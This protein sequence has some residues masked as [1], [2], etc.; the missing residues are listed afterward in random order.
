MDSA[1]SAGASKLKVIIYIIIPELKALFLGYILYYFESN[2]RNA[3]TLGLVG[4]G[5]IGLLLIMDIHLFRYHE[6]CTI[7]LIIIVLI[8]VMDRLSFM[9][10]QRL[11]KG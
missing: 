6:V 3:T 4:A 7:M 10:R 11:I 8:I 1:R 5:G 2:I 9:A